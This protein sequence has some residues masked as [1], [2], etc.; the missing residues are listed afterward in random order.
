MNRAGTD[1]VE[2]VKQ[3]LIKNGYSEEVAEKV[4]YKVLIYS[5][6]IISKVITNCI[7]DLNKKGE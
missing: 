2:K 5:T 6:Y 3:I 1:L 4:K 7:E